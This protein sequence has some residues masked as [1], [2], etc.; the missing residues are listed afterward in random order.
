MPWL[1][2]G[3]ILDLD[4]FNNKRVRE[5]R[6]GSIPDGNGI[7]C[8]YRVRRGN[9]F[10]DGGR[11]GVDTLRRLLRR[12]LS[13]GDRFNKLFELRRRDALSCDRRIVARGMLEL[14]FGAVPARNWVDGM[15]TLRS[16]SIP[17]GFC[18]N[19][20]RGML[21]GIVLGIGGIDH[22]RLC[23]LSVGSVSDHFRLIGVRIVRPGNLFK[24]NGR[25]DERLREL[26]FR[27]V[28]GRSRIIALLR[29]RDGTIPDLDWLD[30]VHFVHGGEL[31]GDDR[32]ELQRVRE[33]HGGSVPD[34]D[35]RDIL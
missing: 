8:V 15:L 32:F 7:D 24:C 34:V 22:E 31:L 6:S 28:C 25:I 21:G 1:F 17:V 26:R 14:C 11:V 16:G 4:R 5:L 23:E 35:R 20:V 10:D 33:L 12:K 19:G 9:V 3:L 2:C 18:V 13:N 30:I 29:L 27:Q